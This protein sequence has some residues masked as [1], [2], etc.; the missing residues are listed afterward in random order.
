MATFPKGSGINVARFDSTGRRIVY[1]DY[2]NGAIA[3]KDLQTGRTVAL[4][5]GPKL[6]WDAPVAPDGQ[7]VAAASAS[8]KLYD[9]AS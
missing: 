9:L 1:A 2:K 6:V 3:V 8:G 7:H 5:G 4:G